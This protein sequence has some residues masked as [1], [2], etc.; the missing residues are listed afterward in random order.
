MMRAMKLVPLLALVLLSCA[1]AAPPSS[2]TGA[3]PG[4]DQRPAPL[5]E[6]EARTIAEGKARAAGYDLEVFPLTSIERITEGTFADSWLCFF[7]HVSPTPPGGH[8]TVYVRDS[9]DA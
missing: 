3:P 4:S 1:S 7:Q 2:G 8:F 5:R 9:G 6:A